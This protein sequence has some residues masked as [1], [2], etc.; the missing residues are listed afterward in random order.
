VD[1]K[2]AAPFGG[3]RTGLSVLHVE[4]PLRVPVNADLAHRVQALLRRGARRIL[5][6]LARVS[7]L[8]A[9]GVGELVHAY[10]MTSAMNGVLQIA[11]TRGRIRELLDRVGLLAL[12][13]A[14]SE[15]EPGTH[16]GARN[17]GR[18]GGDD[19]I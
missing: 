17:M 18:M 7:D 4:G 12:L 14:D 16:R 3:S 5:L 8:D 15:V 9:A 11:H 1:A 6:N 10:N 19:S 2:R 13:S